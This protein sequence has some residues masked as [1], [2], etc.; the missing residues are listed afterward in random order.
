MPK[1]KGLPDGGRCPQNVNNHTVKLPQGDLML[2]PSCEA[3]RFTY[4]RANVNSTMQSI[5]T[6]DAGNIQEETYICQ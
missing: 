6:K 1:C 5:D 2:C 4:I 3:I